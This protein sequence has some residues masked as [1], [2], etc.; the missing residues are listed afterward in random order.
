MVSTSFNNS[1]HTWFKVPFPVLP[2]LFRCILI[3][4]GQFP[5]SITLCKNV[6]WI[7]HWDTKEATQLHALLLVHKSSNRCPVTNNQLSLKVVMWLVT[8]HDA[9]SRKGFRKRAVDW[10]GS[11]NVCT[12]YIT[13]PYYHTI[14]IEIWVFLG[15]DFFSVS[16]F[17]HVWFFVTLWPVAPQAP[18]ST[19]FSKQGY[20]SGLPDLPPGDLPNPGIE[21]TSHYVSCIADGFFTTRAT[22]E[23][24]VWGGGGC[25]L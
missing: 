10:R 22:W 13:S 18:L 12:L 2:L 9:S 24:L 11:N 25:V 17:S 6:M 14:F 8:S 19:G 3:S 23:A 20:W 1:I 15:G 16:R 4:V 21:P 5:L 7:Y